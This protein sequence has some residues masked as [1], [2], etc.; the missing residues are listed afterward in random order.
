MGVVG[1]FAALAA[2]WNYTE[3]FCHLGDNGY[4]YN[5]QKNGWWAILWFAVLFA[6]LHFGGAF[7]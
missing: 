7:K 3:W 5:G 4:Y 2:F 1:F 6:C